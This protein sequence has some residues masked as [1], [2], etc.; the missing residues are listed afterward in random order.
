MTGPV[1]S[2]GRSKLVGLLAVCALTLL[3]IWMAKYVRVTDGVA[4]GFQSVSPRVGVGAVSVYIVVAY[5][6]VYSAVASVRV[7]THFVIQKN[8]SER[9]T[10]KSEK[11]KNV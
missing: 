10:Y 11:L 8:C 5:V 9:Q 6:S 4:V 3:N 1:F 7:T 2:M